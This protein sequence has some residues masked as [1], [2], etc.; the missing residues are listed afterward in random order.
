M[1]TIAKLSTYIV[2]GAALIGTVAFAFL[3]FWRDRK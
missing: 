2:I 1:I 3:V